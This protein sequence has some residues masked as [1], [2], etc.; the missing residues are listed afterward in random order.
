MS[1]NNDL[2]IHPSTDCTLPHV[3]PIPR[4]SSITERPN[5]AP[6][7]VFL[8]QFDRLLIDY[9]PSLNTFR[10]FFRNLFDYYT[11]GKDAYWKKNNDRISDPLPASQGKFWEFQESFEK[12]TH[13]D[14]RMPRTNEP[15][16]TPD[17]GPLELCDLTT[18]IDLTQE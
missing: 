5:E 16:R 10:V 6:D 8:R 14:Y 18:V 11:L 1:S 12:Y 2:P 17:L 13:P 4:H 3:Q 9:E 15:P 7:D